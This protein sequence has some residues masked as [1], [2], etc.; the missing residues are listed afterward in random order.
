MASS[1][2]RLFSTCQK[3]LKVAKSFLGH[4][5]AEMKSLENLIPLISREVSE[6]KTID[7]NVDIFPHWFEERNTHGTPTG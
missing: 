1:R 5:A 3:N 6:V 4:I 2:N 7:I